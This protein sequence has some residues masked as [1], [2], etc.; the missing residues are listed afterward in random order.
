VVWDGRIRRYRLVVRVSHGY[1]FRIPSSVP[2]LVATWPV[3]K[4][5]VRRADSLYI[6]E[7][8]MTSPPPPESDPLD[9]EVGGSE[10]QLAVGTV[11]CVWNHFLRRWTGGFA[12]AE[13]LPSGY[14]LRRLSDGQVFRDVFGTDEVMEERRKLQAPGYRG[15]H[16][17]RRTT[18]S[19]E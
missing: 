4:F 18:D 14:R 1:I 7:D 11:A 17:D 8:H 13:V 3:F 19:G 2:L 15:N 9:A 5:T 12:V 6:Q 16:L 10:G